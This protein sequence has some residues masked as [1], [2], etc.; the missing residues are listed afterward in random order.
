MIKK[1]M[2]FLIEVFSVKD[3]DLLFGN[4]TTDYLI[5]YKS[6]N[7]YFRFKGLKIKIIINI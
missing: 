7:I 1:E 6:K 4:K 3:V 5:I 2:K